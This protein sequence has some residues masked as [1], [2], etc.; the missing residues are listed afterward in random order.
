MKKVSKV[1]SMVVIGGLLVC[2]SACGKKADIVEGTVEQTSTVDQTKLGVGQTSSEDSTE[3]DI[4]DI[5][6]IAI[7][8]ETE[9]ESTKSTVSEDEQSSILDKLRETMGTEYNSYEYSSSLTDIS[10]ETEKSN[11][12]ATRFRQDTTVN[13]KRDK[14]NSYTH[15]V[16]SKSYDGKENIND[17]EVYLF[18]KGEATYSYSKSKDSNEWLGAKVARDL[19]AEPITFKWLSDNLNLDSAIVSS[20]N[21]GGYNIEGNIS[22]AFA[23][24]NSG[25]DL[26]H[27]N[28]DMNNSLVNQLRVPITISVN[29]DSEIYNVHYEYKEQLQSYY[30]TT[31]NQNEASGTMMDTRGG[32]YNIGFSGYNA[33]IKLEIPSQIQKKLNELG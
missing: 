17:I 30:D 2:L 28:V 18:D 15:T 29:K 10:V 24:S 23:L 25:V 13:S 4:G 19:E 3:K 9:E 21:K 8:K 32:E 33:D 31:F 14:T 20:D 6:G 5:S 22:L 1:G 27:K 26:E 11:Y 7:G 16:D 12:S